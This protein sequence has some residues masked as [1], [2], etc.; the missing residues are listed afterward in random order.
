SAPARENA[1][2]AAWRARCA[3]WIP[4]GAWRHPTTWRPFTPPTP[5]RWR[6][7]AR[8]DRAAW[9]R[10]RRGA[11]PAAAG[12]YPPRPAG[13]TH[14][15]GGRAAIGAVVGA[16]PVAERGDRLGAR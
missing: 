12:P 13:G 9:R 16:A 2:F 10:R 6:R 11:C 3:S 14:R 8:P 15:L 7:R 4:P 1:T 5:A